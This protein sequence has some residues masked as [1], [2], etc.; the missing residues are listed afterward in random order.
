MSDQLKSKALG[1]LS[2][3]MVQELSQRGLQF[4]IG[5]LLARLLDPKEFGMV[6]MLT[7]FIAVSQAL[8]DSGFGS[9]LIQRKQTSPADESSVFFFNLAIGLILACLLY[10]CAPFV[11]DFY[12]QP[13]LVD[14]LRVLAI[15]LVINSFALVQN[16]LLVRGLD[17]KSQAMVS[18]TSM[19][20][21][22]SVAL[23][24]A[25]QGFGV[26]S[27]VAQQVTNSLV[28]AIMLWRVNPWRPKW[29]FDFQALR[30]LFRFGSGM[31]G[32]AILNTLFDNLYALVIGRLFSAVTLGHY[33]R[34]YTLQN[35]VSQA[36]AMV[37]NRVTFPLFA[38]L[39]QDPER[40]KRALE[41][42]MT[43]LAFLQFPVLLG[44]AAVAQPLVVVLLTE[45]WLPCVPY[46][47]L[48]CFAG[49]LYPMHLL[50]LNVLTAHGKSGRFFRLEIIKRALVVLNIVVTY[51]WGV[52]AMVCGQ[53][54]N[55]VI[56]FFVNAYYTKDLVG[57]SIPEQ[58]KDL[59]PY[60]VA[61]GLMALLVRVVDLP[62][63]AGHWVSLQ[64]AFKVLVGAIVYGVLC[65]ILRVP[66]LS[67]LR[68]LI[69]R[70][71]ATAAS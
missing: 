25:W 59:S 63:P 61:A 6:A 5:I 11:A 1:A 44:M 18:V 9:A 42:A 52:L 43:G 38:K 15:V 33:T 3:S 30:S 35:I 65:L 14:L 53:A 28:R 22:G 69:G 13:Q 66:A 8:L 39:Q 26:W 4:A 46:L 31:M 12:A 48:L 64:L 40:L 49:I 45:K 27:L 7:I 16:S 2:W 57:Y 47:Q 55:S 62:L 50:N 68:Q 70:R 20:V 24:L 17:F 23:L 56:S 29:L 67:E 54:V 21:S 41:K 10:L 60:F 37:A 71:F 36:P 34:A 32:S 19:I 58:L 51:R